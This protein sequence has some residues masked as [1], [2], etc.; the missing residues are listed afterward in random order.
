VIPPIRFL[1]EYLVFC[2][3]DGVLKEIHTVTGGGDDGG[4][5]YYADPTPRVIIQKILVTY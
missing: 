2:T 1:A 4:K 5:V 3:L